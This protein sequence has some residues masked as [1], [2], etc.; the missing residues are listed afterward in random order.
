MATIEAVE[1]LAWTVFVTRGELCRDDII[2]AIDAVFPKLK[3]PDVIWDLSA[4]S[5]ATMSRADFEGIAQA[6]KAYEATRGSAK[7]VFV[8]STPETFARICMYTGLAAMTEPAVDY[9]AFH[10]LDVA[11]QWL[12][13]NRTHGCCHPG[14]GAEIHGCGEKACQE[15]RFFQATR[16]REKIVPGTMYSS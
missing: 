5:I 11:E 14:A 12:V 7:T 13:C 6:T 1:G 4:A 15:V 2:A 9:S 8:V 3:F 10:T 16:K